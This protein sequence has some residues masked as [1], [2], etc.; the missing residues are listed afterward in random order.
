MRVIYHVYIDAGPILIDGIMHKL[1]K[2][3]NQYFNKKEALEYKERLEKRFKNA[4]IE[5]KIIKN[6]PFI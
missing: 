6:N 5:E 3:F 1:K 4:V 2:E